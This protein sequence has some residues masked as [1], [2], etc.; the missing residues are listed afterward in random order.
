M[1]RVEFKAPWSRS[2]R[3]S[4]AFSLALLAA[5]ALAGL[6]GGTWLSVIGK[7]AMTVL[8][9][10][11]LLSTLPFMVRGYVLTENEIRIERLGWE[12]RLPLSGLQSGGGQGGGG[13]G[14]GSGLC[15]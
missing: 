8:P 13:A 5:M 12:T 4:S 10:T 7:L 1:V 14:P 11:L 6:F 15:D 9:I 2:L 3:L